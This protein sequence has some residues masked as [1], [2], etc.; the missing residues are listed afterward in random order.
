MTFAKFELMTATFE[1]PSKEIQQRYGIDTFP[2]VI[3]F[4]KGQAKGRWVMEYDLGVYRQAIDAVLREPTTK[5]SPPAHR[6]PD[7]IP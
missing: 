6:P 2:T 3:L 5:S 4:S 1:V 7:D